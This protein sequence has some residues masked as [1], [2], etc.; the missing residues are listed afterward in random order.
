MAHLYGQVTDRYLEPLVLRAGTSAAVEVPFAGSPQ[1]K[2]T[3]MVGAVPL[4]DVR[5]VRV[6]TAYNLTTLV[7][8]R[9]ERSDAGTYTLSLENQLGS[10]NLTVQV[11]VLGESSHDQ[12]VT[13]PDHGHPDRFQR[14]NETRGEG[15]RLER[16]EDRRRKRETEGRCRDELGR[17]K[18][19]GKKGKQREW[20]WIGGAA[21]GG[22]STD[23][24]PSKSSCLLSLL[25]A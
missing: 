6:E 21:R 18:R 17:D 23:N 5:R 7:V 11:V 12:S 24:L 10:S 4:R 16:G 13:R 9:A 1:P 19:G 14:K 25:R 2:V 22:D 20:D 15:N 3:W 8:S